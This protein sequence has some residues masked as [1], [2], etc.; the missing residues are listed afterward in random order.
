MSIAANCPIAPGLLPC[1]ELKEALGP[2]KLASPPPRPVAYGE[3]V[4][5]NGTLW[6]PRQ[7]RN[8][9]SFT[10]PLETL[11]N[12]GMEYDVLTDGQSTV[13]IGSTVGVGGALW[14]WGLSYTSVSV[15]G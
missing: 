10:A 9:L 15:A 7:H 2:W 14:R 12:R 3:C 13:G 4:V 5:N 8:V 6:A 11:V 1:V